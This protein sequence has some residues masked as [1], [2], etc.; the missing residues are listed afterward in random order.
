MID[1]RFDAD[2]A[3]VGYGPVGATLAILLANRGRSVV[4]VERWPEPYPLPRAVHMDHEVARIFQACGLGPDLPA[5]TE[6][7][8]IYEWRS[9]DGRTLL[10]LGRHGF[11]LCCWPQSMMF[12]QPALEAALDR[13]ARAVGVDVRRATEVIGLAPDPNGVTLHTADDKEIRA[14]YV[15]G[16]DGA[17]ST[18]R[19]LAGIQF[20]DLG[21]FF[22]WLIVDVILHQPRAFDPINL[23]VC[24]PARPTTAVSGGPGRRRWEFMRLPHET[25]EGLNSIERAWELLEPWDVRPDNAVI[26]RHALYTFNARYAERWRAERVLLAGDSAHQMPP[27]AGQ[28]MCAGIRDAANLAWKLDLVLDESGYD[29]LLDTYEIERRPEVCATIDFSME[30][31]RVICVP[32]P[33]EAEARDE[34]MSAAVGQEPTE[35]PGL[36]PIS[37]GLLD[38]SSQA[39][40]HLFPQ[41]LLDG[42]RFDDLH[43][44]GWRLVTVVEEAR[45][46]PGTDGWFESIGGRTVTVPADHPV[47]GP[48]FAERGCVAALQRPDFHIYGTAHTWSGTEGLLSGLRTRLELSHESSGALS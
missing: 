15:V 27:F 25:I 26:E 32:D 13:R 10:R 31:G 21:F 35:V 34:A 12:N 42:G 22:D 8:D 30:L 43:G 28:G 19:R 17:N 36:P 44:A 4:V 6:A 48:W 41:G 23:Q 14:R 3:V 40:G 37:E 2:V 24:D 47:Y 38:G 7:A 1:S 33:V 16:S 18:V 9:G 5:L 46:N 45:L 11:G 20:H 29:G 39:T